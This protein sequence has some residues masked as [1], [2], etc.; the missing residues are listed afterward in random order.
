MA[1]ILL[2]QKPR[3]VKMMKIK[4]YIDKIQSEK[5]YLTY[6]NQ[7]NHTWY[8]I[9]EKGFPFSNGETETEAVINAIDM[10]IHIHEIECDCYK[11]ALTLLT[12]DAEMGAY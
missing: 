8:V 5:E 2:L 10:G 6:K 12:V 4:N 3:K 11:E 1:D 7:I 9:N